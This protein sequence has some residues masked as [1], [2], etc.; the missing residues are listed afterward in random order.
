MCLIAFEWR[1]GSALPLLLW[2]NRDEF[3][4]RPTEALKRWDNGIWAGRDRQAGGTWLGLSEN[5]G[6]AALTNVREPGAPAGPRSRGELIT[7]FLLSETSPESF[8][9]SWSPEHYSGVNLLLGR[10]D[11]LFFGSNRGSQMQ[12]LS[13]GRYGLS[14]ATLN[15]PWPKVSRLKSLFHPEWDNERALQALRDDHQPDDTAL[16]DTGI[17]LEW[18]R[19]LGRVFIQSPGYGTRSSSV[20]HLFDDGRFDWTEQGYGPQGP[21]TQTRLTGQLQHPIGQDPVAHLHQLAQE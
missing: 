14:N 17:G 12:R 9:R 21:L 6:F 11:Q 16:P 10:G 19:R 18:E 13:P 1:P 4:Q 5:G 3:Y 20:L 2:A 8:L 7:D 15:T